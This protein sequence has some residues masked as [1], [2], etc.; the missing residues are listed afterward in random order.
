M[1]RR[2]LGLP[3]AWVRGAD[4]RPGGSRRDHFFHPRKGGGHAPERMYHRVGKE[5]VAAALR[6]AHPGLLVDIE[7]SLVLA[8]SPRT[9]R[10]AA[11]EIQ[12]SALT[13]AEWRRRS[14]LYATAGVT[15]TWLLGH[16]PPHRL[17]ALG[18]DRD[19]DELTRRTAL[20]DAMLADGRPVGMIDPDARAVARLLCDPEQVSALT[21]GDYTQCF[22]SS[23][24]RV[25]SDPLAGSVLTFPSDQHTARAAAL[26]R[27]PRQEMAEEQDRRRRI[28]RERQTRYE[29]REARRRARLA[30]E[31]A[32]RYA[33]N[34]AWH[35]GGV[36]AQAMAAHEAPDPP[37]RRPVRVVVAVHDRV[38]ATQRPGRTVRR[39]RSRGGVARRTVPLDG[40]VRGRRG[41]KPAAWRS[42]W[43]SPRPAGRPGIRTP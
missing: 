31:A 36:L 33:P 13:E 3:D 9:G 27:H 37:A 38:E 30:E 32:T 5:L 4:L 20:I 43:C 19:R 22:R 23:L 10:R 39:H 17:R 41:R 21:D 7:A 40:S 6:V 12:Y 18:H 34:V 1:R 11:M 25:W 16:L 35:A 2:N 28:Y 8:T 14:G 42:R 15:V 29:Q 26:V 24:A